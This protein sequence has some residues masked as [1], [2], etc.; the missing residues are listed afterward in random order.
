MS[1][2]LND[3][4]E[5]TPLYTVTVVYTSDFIRS[6]LV[7]VFFWWSGQTVKTQAATRVGVLQDR[8]HRPGP[9][10]SRPPSQKDQFPHTEV[11]TG[12]SV[13][14]DGTDGRFNFSKNTFSGQLRVFRI[15]SSGP[16]LLPRLQ[17]LPLKM[18]MGQHP[19]LLLP[20]R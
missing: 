12:L 10:S 18:R 19:R 17:L 16:T 4:R 7:C 15:K 9:P 5:D 3:A 11:R 20:R 6:N 14:Y 13:S 2:K 1:A 8:A